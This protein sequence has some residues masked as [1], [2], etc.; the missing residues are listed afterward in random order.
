MR[1]YSKAS[2]GSES[3]RCG[4]PA[5][6]KRGDGT[7]ACSRRDPAEAERALAHAGLGDLLEGVLG[8]VLPTLRAASAARTRGR[9]ARRGGAR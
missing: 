2:R 4:S 5:S 1:S 3:Q 9:A 7:S 8:D 6:T